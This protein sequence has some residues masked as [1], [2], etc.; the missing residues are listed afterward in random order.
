[1]HTLFLKN[2]PPPN[3][4]SVNVRIM[5]T[6]TQ[7]S[8]ICTLSAICGKPLFSHPFYG[9]PSKNTPPTYLEQPHFLLSLLG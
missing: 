1:M 9:N 8:I 4:S 6:N 5:I 2:W 7:L 3:M